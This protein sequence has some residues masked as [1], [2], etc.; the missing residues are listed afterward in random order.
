LL[1]RP[2]LTQGCNGERKEG[3]KKG[4]K[5]GR[6]EGRKHFKNSSSCC[7]LSCG[8]SY[9]VDWLLDTDVSG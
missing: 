9:N 6:K 1:R 3:R 2:S 7:L 4:R 8:M 5:E